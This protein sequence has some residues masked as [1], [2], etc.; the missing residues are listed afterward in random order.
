MTRVIEP[1]D[2]ELSP[3]LVTAESSPGH[4]LT[5]FR[6]GLGGFKREAARRGSILFRG[7]DVGDRHAFHVFVQQA[8][9]PRD[10]VYGNSPRTRITDAVYTSTEYPAEFPI[11]LHNEVSYCADWPRY[12]LF[13][14]CL[15]ARQGGE[16]PLV[17]SHA[18]WKALPEN[19]RR[20]FEARGL[21]Y[22]RNLHAGKGL[23][24][25]WMQT[26]ATT[27]HE[28]VEAL[29]QAGDVR[30]EWRNDNSLRLWEVR[31]ATRLHP[32]TQEQLWFN[33]ADQFHPTNHPP[34]TRDALM[35]YFSGRETDLPHYCTYAD[36][37]PL[38]PAD[39]DV[40]RET[41]A[42]LA[43]AFTW[44][45]GDLLL[46][47]NMKAAHGRNPYHGAREILVSMF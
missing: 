2:S 27:E 28:Q 31:P 8:V 44:Q 11:S 13:F 39:L 38:D 5:L 25:S 30:F 34:R 41:A 3:L 24:P 4:L 42:N 12:L 19:L 21:L 35:E 16:T 10:Y 45:Q 1:C 23:G 7:F 14:C 6:E 32:D 47:D 20:R 33:Q 18:L 22:I 37:L 40:V 43:T 29:C 17:D 46:V 15:P 36:G 26:F 9:K